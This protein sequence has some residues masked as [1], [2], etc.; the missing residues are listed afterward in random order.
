MAIDLNT[1][2]NLFGDTIATTPDIDRDTLARALYAQLKD[3]TLEDFVWMFTNN[4]EAV[5]D[6]A[7]LCA[8]EKT[9][10]R[11]S[12]LFN[13]HRLDTGTKRFPISLYQALKDDAFVRGLARVVLLNKKKARPRISYTRLSVWACKAQV[14]CRNS[15]HTWRGISRLNMG[16]RNFAKF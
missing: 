15:R 6:Y 10:Q 4:F 11:I 5:I 9:G 1:D 12:L 14:T 7:N 3:A 13:P 16:C 8:G 2:E